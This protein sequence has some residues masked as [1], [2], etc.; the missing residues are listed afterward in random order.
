[1]EAGGGKSGEKKKG[2]MERIRIIKRTDGVQRTQRGLFAR[3]MRQNSDSGLPVEIAV[4]LR[5][6]LD[7]YIYYT[8]GN[9]HT[10]GL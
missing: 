1:M 6:S 3:D 4:L 9:S 7:L 2:E 5:V 10:V 8:A